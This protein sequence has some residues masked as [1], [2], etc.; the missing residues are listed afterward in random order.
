MSETF[1]WVS[2]CTTVVLLL[3]I[4]V[5]GVASCSVKMQQ[6]A[7]KRVAQVCAGDLKADPVR[8]AACIMAV[9]DAKHA[10]Q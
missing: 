10:G 5:G 3:G 8:A 2:G 4:L 9:N 1:Q 7:T 6:E